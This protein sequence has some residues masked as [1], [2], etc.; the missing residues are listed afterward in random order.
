MDKEKNTPLRIPLLI[1][2]KMEVDKVLFKKMMFI[3]NALDDG[4][5]IKKME[6]RY[7]FTKKH[8]G[9]KEVFLDNYLTK[10]ILSNMDIDKLPSSF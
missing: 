10:F 9:K 2:E 3:Y 7:I 1:P 6:D 4:W 5:S 8:E